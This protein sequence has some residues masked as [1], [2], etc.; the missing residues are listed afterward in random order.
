MLRVKHI[1]KTIH[2]TNLNWEMGD[3]GVVHLKKKVFNYENKLNMFYHLR[4][5]VLYNDHNAVRS[6]ATLA[7]R[8]QHKPVE[9][10]RKIHCTLQMLFLFR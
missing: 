4:C 8:T 2:I 5:S 7:F 6:P 9:C 1:N 10:A 3:L